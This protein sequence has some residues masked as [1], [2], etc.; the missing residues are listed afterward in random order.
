VGSKLP[1][2][3]LPDDADDEPRVKVR[4]PLSSADPFLFTQN[5]L[6][7]LWEEAMN[8]QGN[9]ARPLVIHRKIPVGPYEL[10]VVP[11]G[12]G[13]SSIRAVLQGMPQGKEIEMFTP[14]ALERGSASR[15]AIAIWIYQNASIAVVHLDFQS[16]QRYILWDAPDSHQFNYENVEELRIRL[17]TMNL[18]IPDRLDRILSK[19]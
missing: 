18:E 12:R 10:A 13:R 17:S 8:A 3:E 14:L 4:V 16:K 2:E 15:T 7:N 9:A 1:R 11:T 5:S 19:K 6:R